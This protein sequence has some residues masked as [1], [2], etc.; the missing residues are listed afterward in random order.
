MEET[1]DLTAKAGIGKEMKRGQKLDGPYKMTLGRQAAVPRWQPL[2]VWSPLPGESWLAKPLSS[3]GLADVFGS[4]D[5]C[6]LPSKR[7]LRDWSPT[8]KRQ[9]TGS[10]HCP[11]LIKVPVADTNGSALAAAWSCSFQRN[12]ILAWK[13]DWVC[14]ADCCNSRSGWEAKV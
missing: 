5:T 8:A 7:R 4:E 14:L 13:P 6:L 9:R 1:S 3:L 12:S 11:P 2:Q 10:W